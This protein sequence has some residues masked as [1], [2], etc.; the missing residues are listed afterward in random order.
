MRHPRQITELIERLATL[1][2]LGKKSATRLAL[3]ILKRPDEEIE[4][5]ASAMV[6]VKKEI[7]FC[8]VCHDYTA[9]DPCPRCLDPARD[10]ATVCV[11]E[12]PADLMVIEASGLFRGLYHV[13]GGAVNPLSGVGP[14]DLFVGDLV[15]R[16]RKS[17]DT[18]DPVTEVLMATGSS[19]E[20]ESTCS[21]LL[22]LLGEFDLK[23]TKLARG[24][25]SGMDLEY[26]DGGTLKD[27]LEF[28]RV[29]K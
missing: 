9:Q 25:P 28:R 23:V 27:A 20:G 4:A 7:R 8:S 17:L 6:A 11:V 3:H 15:E 10:R 24:L 18:P 14:N 29:V 22:D 1:P 16:I 2:G 5:L 12:S 19:P 13:L 26:V 21:L